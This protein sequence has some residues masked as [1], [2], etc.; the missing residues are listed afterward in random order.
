MALIRSV[1]GKKPAFGDDCWLADNATVVGDVVMG[2]KCTVWFNAVV[3]GDVNSIRIGHH[4][5]IQ[6]GAVI[7]CTYQRFATSIG[8]YVS[9][10]HNAIVH[11]CTIEDRVLIGMGAIVMDGAVV[12]EGAIVAAGAIVTQGTRV[13]PGSIYAGNPARFLKKVSP[14]LDEGI[15]RTA[16]NYITYAGW[17]RAEEEAQQGT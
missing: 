15:T 1:Q 11:G 7:H 10:A 12:G 2:E 17:F 14:E 9:I 16:N 3:R 8:N 13:E 4:S 5:N 6:D